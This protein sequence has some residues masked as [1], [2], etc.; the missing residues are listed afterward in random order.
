MVIDLR[1][2]EPMCHSTDSLSNLQV[3]DIRLAVSIQSR[4]KCIR[5]LLDHDLVP[6]STASRH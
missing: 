4:S 2:L 6:V 3:A 1:S 5:A